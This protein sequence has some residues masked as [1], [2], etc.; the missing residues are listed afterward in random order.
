MDDMKYEFRLTLTPFFIQFP[1]FIYNIQCPLSWTMSMCIQSSQS[2]VF[3][4]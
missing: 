2:I 1:L 4:S 3:G